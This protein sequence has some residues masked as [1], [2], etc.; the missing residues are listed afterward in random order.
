MT[1]RTE[2]ASS[3]ASN[4][5]SGCA[6]AD[7]RREFLRTIAASAA[8]VLLTIGVS[9][10]IARGMAPRFLAGTRRNDQASY[11]V[12]D[13]D[14]VTIDKDNAV[15]LARYKNV[16]YAFAL[17]CPHQNTSL[18]WM[19]SDGRFQCP[20]HKSRYQ[21]DGE[22]IDG[23]ATRGMDRYAIRKDAGKIVVDL[24]VVFEQDKDAAGWSGARVVL[25]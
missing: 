18:K 22:F 1:S 25:G 11:P 13:T 4:A 7:G 24:N 16:V 9:P 6:L 20:K 15:I 17:A 3:G 10:S 5:C 8:G 14:C 2:T 12:P 21:P 19:P 23:R